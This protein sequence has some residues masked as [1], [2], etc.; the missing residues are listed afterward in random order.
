M[1]RKITLAWLILPILLLSL[2]GG[3]GRSKAQ[4]GDPGSLIDAVNN[5]RLNNGLPAYQV[6]GILMS[7]AQD[8]TDYQ[9]AIGECTHTGSGGTRPKDRAA[10][11]GYGGGATFFMSENFVCGTNMSIDE[12]ISI[13]LGDAPHTQTMLGASYVDAGAGVTVVDDFV[14]YTLDV[15]YVAGSG[16]YSPA[17][18]YTPGGPTAI[19]IY[20]V[21]TATPNP[22]GSII[23]TVRSGQTLITIAKGY[24]ITL[25]ELKALNNL[26]SDT[27]YEG[28]KLLIRKASTPG[29]TST[30][31]VTRTP[32]KA[33]TPT[34]KPTRTPTS[35]ITP[36]LPATDAVL[37]Q[38]AV[39]T[40]G[41]DPVGSVMIVAIIVMAGGGIVLM[42]AG[43]L[44]K[45][46]IRPPGD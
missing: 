18:T 15:A 24:G 7:I 26:A 19:P 25:A 39:E 46:R 12:A 17:A 30:M 36:T 1:Q 5:L 4:A 3:V 14:Y 2:A 21:Q 40:A 44:L 11:A 23:H 27:I 8:Q 42:V 10:A 45:R 37:A 34:R 32:T 20:L 22:D 9:A 28:Q 43:S 29:P 13:W 38:A 16:N 31:T 35:S 6:N 33:A 41:S